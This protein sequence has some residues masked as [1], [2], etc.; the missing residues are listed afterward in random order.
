MRKE[1]LNGGGAGLRRADTG[2]RKLLEYRGRSRIEK[3]TWIQEKSRV[4]KGTIELRR[5][6]VEKG[7]YRVE[8]GRYR[9]EKKTR[10]Q[11]RSRV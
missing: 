6:R 2:L 5:S 1:Q 11:G 8:K 7:R 3:G 9:V 4:E 10:I